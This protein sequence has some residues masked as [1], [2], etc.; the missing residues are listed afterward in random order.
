MLAFP[1]NCIKIPPTGYLVKFKPHAQQ[2]VWI[3]EP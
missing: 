1:N 2:S 3:N